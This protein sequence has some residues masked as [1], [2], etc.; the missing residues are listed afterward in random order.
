MIPAAG[1]QVRLG[2]LA[3]REHWFEVPLDRTRPDGEMITLFAREAVSAEKAATGAEAELPWLLFLQGG[4]GGKA[5]RPDGATGWV[6]RAVR[7]FRVLLLDQRGTGRSTP[8]TARTL[9][10]RGGAD[11]QAAYLGHF[12][13]DSIVADAEVVR[14]R[15]VGDDGRWS[16]LG[17]SYGGFCALTYL[18]MA[19]DA[20]TAVYLTGGLAPL[21]ASAD[22]VYSATY[23]TVEAKNAAFRRAFPAVHDQIAA[24]AD[25]LRSHAVVLP[26]GSPLTVAR[27]QSLG[28]GLGTRSAYPSLAY[29]FEEAF[30]DGRSGGELSDTFLAGVWSRTSFSTNPLYAIMHESIYGQ[31]EPTRWAADRVRG[32]FP[33]FAPDADPV[34]LTGEMIY[35]WMFDVDP[36]LRPL[37]ETA[38]VLAHRTWTPL[39]DL[40]VLARN[41]VPVAAALYVD[42]MFV[43]ATL[44][45]RAAA[46][47]A[48]TRVWETN[49]HEHDGLRESADV[50]DRLI[51][52]ARGEV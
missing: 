16:V 47:V 32:A 40:D 37:R 12:R 14:R 17:Q 6:G 33:Q 31:S 11:A 50:L 39:Y 9:A 19:P 44:A 41:T 3:L 51:R 52:I 2:G 35:P 8:A 13:A 45:R 38:E 30:A 43:D 4:P 48:N 42:D 29:L 15:L 20:L 27:L 49:A 22:D 10:A 23:R 28:L 5:T 21:T 7:D 18:S 26:D 34:L 24:V 46:S 36:A 1:D 25:H